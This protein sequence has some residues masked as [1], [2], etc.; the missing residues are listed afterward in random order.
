M[1]NLN[2]PKTHL[3]EVMKANLVSAVPKQQLKAV[4]SLLDLSDPAADIEVLKAF[5]RLKGSAR[6]KAIDVLSKN[7]MDNS[8]ELF[9]LLNNPSGR[10]RENAVYFL[11]YPNLEISFFK[12]MDML[13]DSRQVVQE[14]AFSILRKK[15]NVYDFKTQGKDK[16]FKLFLNPLMNSLETIN[17]DI[18]PKRL[19]LIDIM[20]LIIEKM[21]EIENE[22]LKRFV[23]FYVNS[24]KNIFD[25]VDEKVKTLPFYM[26]IKIFAIILN[27]GSAN[28]RNYFI[29]L[30]DESKDFTEFYTVLNMVV[31]ASHEKLISLLRGDRTQLK[32]KEGIEHYKEMSS[33]ELLSLLKSLVILFEYKALPLEKEEIEFI[34]TTL[35]S[36]YFHVRKSSLDAI[37]FNDEILD[38]ILSSEEYKEQ[39]FTKLSKLVIDPLEEIR[40]KAV[41]ILSGQ[42]IS[43]SLPIFLRALNTNVPEIKER[44]VKYIKNR[45]I[46]YKDDMMTQSKKELYDLGYKI[47]CKYDPTIVDDLYSKVRKMDKSDLDDAMLTVKYINDFDKL[48]DTL[49]R[50]MK[51]PDKSVRAFTITLISMLKSRDAF[52]IL[53]E[54]LNDPDKRV[55][56]NVLEA[57][58]TISS[59]DDLSIFIPFVNDENNRVRANV[60]HVL[61]T[62]GQQQLA[63]KILINMLQSSAP[64]MKASALWVIADLKI[65]EF[66][67]EVEKFVASYDNEIRRNALKAKE[68]LGE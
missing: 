9:E 54:A 36:P 57:L 10:L 26:R 39:F 35:S 6:K 55:V 4:S 28:L 19:F 44:I 37:A 8:N 12:L 42:D 31:S 46:K 66:K 11:E 49:Y 27:K 30:L 61:Y 1:D 45:V 16:V 68:A 25:K 65:K 32:L 2:L 29:G 20:C 18:Y 17:I 63:L 14:T 13:D 56:A 40:K 15:C 24:K 67:D 51:N 52:N 50:L 64:G 7:F 47:L 38:E 21:P 23:A 22:V 5:N 3:I 41:T 34:L 59:Q 62:L 53:C 48:R 60:A 33:S 58:E 43:M